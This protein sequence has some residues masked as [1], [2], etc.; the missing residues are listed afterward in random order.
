MPKTLRPVVELSEVVALGFRRNRNASG[1]VSVRLPR[2]A[3][4]STLV[5]LLDAVLF[6]EKF[7][8]L[9]ESFSLPFWDVRSACGALT[10]KSS[11]HSPSAV[12]VFRS[13]RHETDISEFMTGLLFRFDRE[14][15]ISFGSIS[16]SKLED[17]VPTFLRHL[18]LDWEFR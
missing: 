2:M 17:A 18:D 11:E 14:A 16:T 4:A 7:G 13:F 6:G 5:S 12:V 8:A 3:T 9:T 15:S 1:A 10:P